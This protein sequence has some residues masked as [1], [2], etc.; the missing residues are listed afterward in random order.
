MFK[1]I[2]ENIIHFILEKP[3]ATLLIGFVLLATMVM[4]VFSITSDYTPRIWF[5]KDSEQ[6]QYLNKFEE[7]F[8]GDQFVTLGIYTGENIIQKDTLDKIQELTEEL[9]QLPDAIRVESITNFNYVDID[10]DDINISP[11]VEDTSKREEIL[12]KISKVKEIKNF[13][14]SENFKYTILHVQMKP[15]FGKSPNYTKIMTALRDKLKKFENDKFQTFALGNISVTYAFREIATGDNRKIIPFMFL[16]VI[17]L[18]MVYYR[19]A[20]GV[21]IPLI[22]T[23]VTIGQTF[24]LLGLFGMVFNSILASIPGILLAICLADSIHILTTFYQQYN[25]GASKLHSLRYTLD[26]NFLATLLTSITTSVSFYTISFTEIVPIANLG[27]LAGIGTALA[28]INT[29][30]FLPP[31]IILLPDSLIK[32]VIASKPVKSKEESQFAAFIWK[33]KYLI[34]IFFSTVS[35]GSVYLALETEVNSDPLKYF[36]EET[37]L[38]NDYN[39][40]KKHI[41]SLRGI[42]IVVDSGKEDGIKDPKFLLN[43]DAFISKLTEDPEIEQAISIIDAV[44]KVNQQ[45]NQGKEEYYKIPNDRYKIA[46]TI[47]LYTMGLP[48]GMGIEN[49]VSI[50]N[51]YMKLNLRWTLEKTKEAMNKNAM[52]HEIAKSMGLS[53]KTGGYF[54]IYASVNNQV[55]H[56][57]FKSMTMALF[58]VAVFIFI[59]FRNPLLSFLAM[60]PNVIPLA[61]GAA[62]MAT[63]GIY[64]DIGT[65]I[66][67]AICLGIAVDDTIHFLTHY[68]SNQKKFNNTYQALN[69]TF[70]ST[71][72]ALI[73]TTII[74]VVGFG[75]FIM[76]DFLP[77]HYFGIL[78]SI[79]LTFA[80]LTDLLF[81]PAILAVWYNKDK[82]TSQ[83]LK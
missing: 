71:G 72:K 22:V 13:I 50:D 76:A 2:K 69:E 24:G 49:Q 38:K 9:W 48:P 83:E 78:C 46:E 57:F 45:L 39:F 36:A 11:L 42:H 30:L 33:F 64:L 28:W 18:L 23:V 14:L 17:I 19:S 16:F 51:R 54:P 66:V 27:V 43:V 65:S 34:I 74:L 73:M 80:L 62:Y 26:K 58:F 20:S 77:N 21:L 35:V 52:I 37:K 10:G 40:S 41:K 31:L 59:F 55:V 67:A 6:I 81:L 15:L 1:N 7:T 56:S 47:F 44:K 82:E 3:K 61:M 63:N 5:A 12:N 75:S 25:N 79:V 8:G 29:F 32:Q 70:L 60:L 53:T 4:G 68:V